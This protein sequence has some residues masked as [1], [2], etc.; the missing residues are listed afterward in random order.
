MFNLDGFRPDAMDAL[1]GPIFHVSIIIGIFYAW[2]IGYRKESKF[3]PGKARNMK[4]EFIVYGL[5]F[6]LMYA[7]GTIKIISSILLIL[8]FF[9]PIFL[10]PVAAVLCLVMGGAV[11]MHLKIREDKLIKAFPSYYLF[12]C[13][14]FLL[15]D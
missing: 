14:V 9:Y 13:C 15:M 7:T 6:W 11:L 4:E 8:G 12:C 3:R 10:K 1:V 2:T 5:P